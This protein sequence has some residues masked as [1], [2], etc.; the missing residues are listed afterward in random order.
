MYVLPSL[1]EKFL[2]DLEWIWRHS[3][4]FV[5]TT[6]S[7]V[8]SFGSLIHRHSFIVP[9]PSCSLPPPPSAPPLG[10]TKHFSSFISHTFFESLTFRRFFSGPVLIRDGP[11]FYLCVHLR[12]PCCIW[13]RIYMLN[14]VV[15][16]EPVCRV[17]WTCATDMHAIMWIF[18]GNIPLKMFYF[19]SLNSQQAWTTFVNCL[20]IDIHRRKTFQLLTQKRRQTFSQQQYPPDT[21]THTDKHRAPPPA[22][23]L[24]MSTWSIFK[25]SSREIKN[26]SIFRPMEVQN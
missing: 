3:N 9:T 17:S 22:K 10:R 24:K 5:W 11:I 12:G 7:I 16:C 2:L 8:N 15:G 25:S 6:L 23:E 19:S 21:H 1:A 26:A 4:F 18:I 13:M 20:Y 14:C